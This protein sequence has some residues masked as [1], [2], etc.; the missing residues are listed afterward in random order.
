MLYNKKMCKWKEKGKRKK[1]E[2]K[3]LSVIN[4]C[5][6][7]LGIFKVIKC[8]QGDPNYHGSIKFGS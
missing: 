8:K 5:L 7:V 3:A 1:K 4:I 2:K 6:K